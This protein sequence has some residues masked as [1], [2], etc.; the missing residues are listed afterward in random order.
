MI[1]VSGYTVKKKKFGSTS[2][3]TLGKCRL[4]KKKNLFLAP[5]SN[6]GNKRTV[7]LAL[8]LIQLKLVTCGFKVCERCLE[9]KTR[10]C[11]DGILF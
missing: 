2:S 1:F 10:V 9:L 4:G 7:L 11:K 6:L 8:F 5:N 3:M